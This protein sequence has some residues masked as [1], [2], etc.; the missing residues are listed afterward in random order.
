[1]G[2]ILAPFSI[3]A[4]REVLNGFFSCYLPLLPVLSAMAIAY[5]L[6]EGLGRLACLSF[7][8]C[9]GKPLRD[10]GPFMRRL[11]AGTATVFHGPIKKAEYAGGL[12]GEP[13]VPVQA[14]TCTL[15]TL[16]ALAGCWLFLLG[17]FTATLVGCITVTQLWRIFSEMLRA[18]FRGFGKISAYQKM[19]GLAVLYISAIAFIP[20]SDILVQP[21][22]LTGISRLWHPG[23]ILGLQLSWLIFF[24]YFGRSTVTSATVSFTL[25]E[26]RI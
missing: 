13:L 7:G 9:Y 12:A 4:S 15:F 20:M 21:A 23:V 22:I 6:G 2:I 5:T 10:C 8:C 14:M 25:R 24:L 16:T 17:H 26:E 19:G 11:F 3:I 1:M 18:D